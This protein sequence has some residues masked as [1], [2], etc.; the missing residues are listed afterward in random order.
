[1]YDDPRFQKAVDD[2]NLFE[3]LDDCEVDYSFSGKNIGKDFIG[4][5]PCIFCNDSRRHFAIHKEQ[6]Y[7][8]CFKCGGRAGPLK[9]ISYYKRMKL[10]DAFKYLV[11]RNTEENNVVDTVKGILS[12]TPKMIEEKEDEMD[13]IPKGARPISFDDLR[14]NKPLKT[15][16]DEK[17][18]RFWDV[19]RYNLMLY[20]NQLVMPIYYRG[21]IV[22]YQKRT[23]TE[24][25]YINSENTGRYIY[26]N[27]NI[28]PN[29]HLILVEGFFDLTRI[30]SYILTNKIKVSITTAFLKMVSREQFNKIIMM[31]P[32]SVIVMFDNDSWFNYRRV[33]KEMPF[34]THFVI[35]PKGKD[36]N[37]L[38]WEEMKNIFENEINSIL[39][40]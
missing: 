24:K 10:K 8:K 38:R 19:E 14:T 31:K 2:W 1:M 18:L 26:W 32:K 25:N 11:G 30:Y 23:I 39:S 36:P 33:K 27:R 29:A 37:M 16:F 17:H 40:Y 28:I 3:F 12:Y 6:K 13:S 35:L 15:L 20:G 22:S 4:I 21:N 34:D 7:G 9:L 5:N